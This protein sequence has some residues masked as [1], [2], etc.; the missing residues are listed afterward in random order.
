MK[1][2]SDK[3]IEIL[4]VLFKDFSTD[5]NANNITKK[6]RITPA[7]AF[8]AMKKLEKKGLI[9]GKKMGKAVFY[10]LNLNDYYTFRTME[11]LLI[12][13]SREKASRWLEEFKDLF[14]HVEIAIIFGS[15]IKYPKKANDIDLLV[16]FKKEKNNIVNKII[17]E[18]RVLLIKAI[19]LVKQTPEDLNKNLKNKVILSAIKNGCILHG[20]DKLLGVIKN[21]TSI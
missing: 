11:T 12:S 5:Y 15:I 4:L 8:K 9:T 1:G 18:R 19:H 20:Y 14:N 7:G 3:E 10:K 16:I 21:V 13:E 17:D 2:L 6:I